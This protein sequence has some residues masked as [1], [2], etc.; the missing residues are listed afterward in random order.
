[1]PLSV[2]TLFGCGKP[3]PLAAFLIGVDMF[4]NKHGG[5]FAAG[6]PRYLYVPDSNLI[7][8]ITPRAASTSMRASIGMRRTMGATNPTELL[9]PDRVIGK[10]VNVVMWLRH[11]GDRIASGHWLFGGQV[12]GDID[13]YM[14]HIMMESNAH[15]DPMTYMHSHEERLLPNLIYPFE[16]LQA[17]WDMLLPG[18]TLEREH[19]SPKRV[20]WVDMKHKISKPVLDQMKEHWKGDIDMYT[21][22]TGLPAI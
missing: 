8:C 3:S 22:L 11:V 7:V 2:T 12:M 15:W 6:R 21:E 18:Y 14:R 5:V 4:A 10:G 19:M 9:T 13:T 16:K 20:Q 1:M 17:T